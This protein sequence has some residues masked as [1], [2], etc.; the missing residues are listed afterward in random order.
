MRKV[1]V[2]EKLQRNW[3]SLQI[4]PESPMRMV[5]AVGEN[6]IGDGKVLAAVMCQ[7]MC[8][9]NRV[10]CSGCWCS[11]NPGSCASC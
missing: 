8:C 9:A 3:Q 11:G 7:K 5:L 1:T 2:L 4:H 6:S 10:K